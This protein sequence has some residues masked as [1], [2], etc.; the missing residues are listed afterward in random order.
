MGAR[1]IKLEADQP[2]GTVTPNTVLDDNVVDSILAGATQDWLFLE[3][4]NVGDETPATDVTGSDI[5]T[6]LA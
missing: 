5:V 3:D 6:D 2:G 4:N 1:T